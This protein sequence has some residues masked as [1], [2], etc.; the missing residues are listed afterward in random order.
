MLTFASHALTW[1]GMGKKPETTYMKN[2]LKK[3]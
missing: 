1:G 2:T 3:S